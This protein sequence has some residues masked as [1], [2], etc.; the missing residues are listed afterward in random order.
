[1]PQPKENRVVVLTRPTRLEELTARYNSVAQAKF[2]VESRGADFNDYLA[3]HEVYLDSLRKTKAAVARAGLLQL[4]PRAFLPN[5]VF[6]KQ[7]ILVALG[8][9][10]LVANLLK[11]TDN[12][13]VL[14]VNPDPARWD[15]PLLPFS[16]DEIEGAL[17]AT[18]DGT[19]PEQKIS[20]AQ[21]LL[22]DGQALIAVNDFFVG[23]KSHT[24]A[25]YRLTLGEQTEVQSSSGL[26]VSTGLGSGAWLTSVV[27]GA[28]G[29][30]ALADRSP[31][32]SVDPRMPWDSGDLIFAVREPFPTRTTGCSLVYG[33]IAP[34]EKLVLESHMAENGVIFSDGIEHDFLPFVAGTTATIS[35][36][37]KQGRLIRKKKNP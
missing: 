33:K 5:F 11:Y 9:D 24:S 19:A 34:G 35:L 37:Q 30:A 31:P 23:P 25:R 18:F 6:G 32:H 10:G 21:V 4:L 13:P 14:G 28:G 12:H 20:M 16:P 2:M 22:S 26:L 17:G 29:I 8:Q 27:T 36:A 15:G 3:E 7:D 1:M